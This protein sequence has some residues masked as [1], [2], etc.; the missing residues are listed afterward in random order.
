MDD[1]LE[2]DH[3]PEFPIFGLNE[4]TG[5]WEETGSFLLSGEPLPEKL[6]WRKLGF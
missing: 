3:D 4:T 5:E 6:D 2:P 1:T